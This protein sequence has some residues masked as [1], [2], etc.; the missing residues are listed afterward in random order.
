VL[1]LLKYEVKICRDPSAIIG[2]DRMAP[3]L[4]IITISQI[5]DFAFELN[6]INLHNDWK[7][8]PEGCRNKARI[9]TH[10]IPRYIPRHLEQMGI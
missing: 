4:T 2:I 6:L 8:E 5:T 7:N 3:K 1:L 10:V 9:N